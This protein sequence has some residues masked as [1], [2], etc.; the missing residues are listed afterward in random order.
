MF[1]DHFS[2]FS[3]VHNQ[4]SADTMQTIEAKRAFESCAKA[5]GVV[6]KHHHA[7]NGTF[8]WKMCASA[9]KASLKFPLQDPLQ[10]VATVATTT[11][12]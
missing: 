12:P 6:I 7:D 1:V 10:A 8:S 4:M 9:T 3:F 11:L 2:G 5:H